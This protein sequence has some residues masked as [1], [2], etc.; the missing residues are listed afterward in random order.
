MHDIMKYMLED[1]KSEKPKSF[2]RS[3]DLYTDTQTILIA[4]T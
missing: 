1:Y 4:A 2:L 3:T